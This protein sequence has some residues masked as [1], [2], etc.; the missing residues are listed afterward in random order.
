MIAIKRHA[1]AALPLFLLIGACETGRE[2]IPARLEVAAPTCATAPNLTAAVAVV[3]EKKDDPYKATVRFDNGAPCLADAKGVKSV[4][5]VVDIA[6]AETGSILTVTSYAF[7]TTIFSPKLQ[8]RDAQGALMREVGRETFMFN[9]R[10]LQTQLRKRDGERFLVIA[11]DGASVGQS[12]EQIQSNRVSSGVMVGYVY[13]PI[14]TGAEAKAQLV[15]AHNGEV[16][17]TLAPMPKA[18]SKK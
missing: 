2:A 3:Q 14:N 5:G 4:Y 6:A 13:V 7:G 12:V 10:A 1:L 8:F 16:T 11:S 18:D 15:F 17:A 9:G